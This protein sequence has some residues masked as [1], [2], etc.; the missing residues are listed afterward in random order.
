MIDKDIFGASSLGRPQCTNDGCGTCTV[1]LHSFFL[2]LFSSDSAMEDGEFS[3][4]MS[5]NK[6]LGGKFGL[7]STSSTEKVNEWMEKQSEKHD[8]CKHL[9]KNKSKTAKDINLIKPTNIANT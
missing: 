1:S 6:K 2:L 7:P 9:K 8:K 4:L 5:K 3:S